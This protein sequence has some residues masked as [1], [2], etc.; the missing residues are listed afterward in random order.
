LKPSKKRPKLGEKLVSTKE[1]EYIHCKIQT[2][3]SEV[4]LRFFKNAKTQ[5]MKAPIHIL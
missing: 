4:A 2:K 5:K 3:V 1:S